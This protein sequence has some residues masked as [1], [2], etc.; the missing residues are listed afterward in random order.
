[1]KTNLKLLKMDKNKNRKNRILNVPWYLQDVDGC[2]CLLL[3]SSSITYV[4]EPKAEGI[5][6]VTEPLALADDPTTRPPLV[7]P[8]SSGFCS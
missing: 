6:P 7:D 2:C 4:N 1:M 3:T 5:S 8:L